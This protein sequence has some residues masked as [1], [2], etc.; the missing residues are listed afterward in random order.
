LQLNRDPTDAAEL[1]RQAVERAP[2]AANYF[3]WSV[4]SQR[5]GDRTRAKAA[6]EKALEL[7]PGNA[8]YQQLYLSLAAQR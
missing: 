5:S 6:I 8:Q 1:A 7:D 4:A 3:L 2:T